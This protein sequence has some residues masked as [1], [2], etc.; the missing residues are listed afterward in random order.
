MR[1]FYAVCTHDKNGRQRRG[2]A[3]RLE[4]LPVPLLS[5]GHPGSTRLWIMSRMST[6]SQGSVS[7]EVSLYDNLARILIRT[8]AAVLAAYV[9][10]GIVVV[11]G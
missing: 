7:R 4:T 6:H 10:H 1:K 3:G 5:S 11:T 8:F 9:A 2:F